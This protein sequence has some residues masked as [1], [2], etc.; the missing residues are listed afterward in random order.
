MADFSTELSLLS[1]REYTAGKN[2]QD[3]LATMFERLIGS[4]AFTIAMMAEGDPQKM[5]ELLAGAEAYLYEAAAG[6]A[7]MARFL[8][9]ATRGG[10]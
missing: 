8:A 5:G 2:D 6:H 7:E 10:R 9:K 4:A 3:R 1:T